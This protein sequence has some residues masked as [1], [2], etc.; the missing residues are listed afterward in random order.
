MRL[1]SIFHVQVSHNR[2]YW[3]AR[4]AEQ[5]PHCA[6]FI[7]EATFWKKKSR[8]VGMI[9]CSQFVVSG[10]SEGFRC[11][12]YLRSR[13]PYLGDMGAGYHGLRMDHASDIYRLPEYHRLY[14]SMLKS[15]KKLLVQ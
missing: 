9:F 14:P 11:L 7:P 15:L 3:V 13:K 6:C 5:P 12:T 4:S 2:F 1:Y 8:T 10:K